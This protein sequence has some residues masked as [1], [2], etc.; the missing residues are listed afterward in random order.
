MSQKQLSCQLRRECMNAIQGV[1]HWNQP[2]QAGL[3]YVYDCL[4]D[5]GAA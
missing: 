5:S 2:W 4:G 1:G 3:P